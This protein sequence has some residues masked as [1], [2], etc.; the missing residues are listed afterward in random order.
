V[1]FDSARY[2]H[3]IGIIVFVSHYL[4]REQATLAQECGPII[5]RKPKDLFQ[6]LSNDRDVRIADNVARKT[7]H[8]FFMLSLAPK[9]SETNPKIFEKTN[10]KL[11]MRIFN[12]DY[13]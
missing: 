8:E 4:S 10:K 9:N 11:M 1:E 6:D 3:E 13:V 5:R 2:A 12:G 7:C